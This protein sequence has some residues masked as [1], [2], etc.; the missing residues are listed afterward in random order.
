MHLLVQESLPCR[1]ET[2]R[3]TPVQ[4]FNNNLKVGPKSSNRNII[5]F[6]SQTRISGPSSRM[7]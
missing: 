1:L 4:A 7:L 5:L 2:S 3:P 6:A